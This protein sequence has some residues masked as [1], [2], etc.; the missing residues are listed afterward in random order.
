MATVLPLSHEISPITYTCTSYVA[1][2]NTNGVQN[3]KGLRWV[4]KTKKVGPGAEPKTNIGKSRIKGFQKLKI[5][6]DTMSYTGKRGAQN[7]YWAA[8]T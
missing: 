5:T 4:H 8:F 6:L 7:K 2:G 1:V 3:N